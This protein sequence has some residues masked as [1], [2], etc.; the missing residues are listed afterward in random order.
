[1]SRDWSSDVCSSDLETGRGLSYRIA[2]NGTVI[3]WIEASG[4]TLNEAYTIH[5]GLSKVERASVDMKR[6]V[7]KARNYIENRELLQKKE[8]RPLGVVKIMNPVF[9]KVSKSEDYNIWN[10]VPAN[11]DA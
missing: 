7:L 8:E 6:K 5:Q 1:F 10:Q 2:V 11:E 3:G 9:V 4:L